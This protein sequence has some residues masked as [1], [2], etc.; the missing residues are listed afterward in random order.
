LTR[1]QAAEQ[2]ACLS[3]LN[4]QCRMPNARVS[5]FSIRHSSLTR[6][7]RLLDPPRDL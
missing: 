7:W 4:A 2:E 6:F 1:E 5:A 3:M